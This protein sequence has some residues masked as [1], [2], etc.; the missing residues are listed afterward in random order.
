MPKIEDSSDLILFVQ[1]ELLAFPKPQIYEQKRE[2]TKRAVAETK[3]VLNAVIQQF[4]EIKIVSKD[5]GKVQL[6][7]PDPEALCDDDIS[8][9]EEILDL[10]HNSEKV[11]FITVDV[12]NDI[13]EKIAT[14]KADYVQ[15]P[16]H[17]GY[18]GMNQETII[19]HK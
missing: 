7:I 13:S 5:N 6:N 12:N 15:E 4:P 8:L 18:Q 1:W 14:N 10:L 11:V 2:N 19:Y 9:Y 3:K 16:W 17:S